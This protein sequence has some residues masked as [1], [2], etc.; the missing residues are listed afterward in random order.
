VPSLSLDRFMSK[1]FPSR[2]TGEVRHSVSFRVI[3][4]YDL[5]A[6]NF[7]TDIPWVDGDHPAVFRRLPELDG[8]C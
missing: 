7:S 5:C 8:H 3:E 1:P 6:A 4:F 2:V